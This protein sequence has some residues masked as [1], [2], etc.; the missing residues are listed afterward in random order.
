MIRRLTPRWRARA[1]I[2]ALALPPLVQLVSIER[3]AA[4][5]HRS[6]ARARPDDSVDDEALAE[7]V[8]RV[9]NHLPP[10]WHRTCLRRAVVLQYLLQRTGRPAELRIGVRRDPSGT[11]LAHAWLT[12]HDQ[13]C[14]EPGI[15]QASSYQVITT[16]P[17]RSEQPH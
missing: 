16:L 9:L 12:R 17:S 14:L 10:P 5:I 7:W 3:I 11:L 8:D 4:W 6:N 1:T 2:A 13:P 15:D